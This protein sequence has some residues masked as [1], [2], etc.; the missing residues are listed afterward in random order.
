MLLNNKWL[1]R[2]S[3]IIVATLLP[4]FTHE[5]FA[6]QT[7]TLDGST[8]SDS[9]HFSN[10]YLINLPINVGSHDNRILIVTAGCYLGFGC[11]DVTKVQIN[12]MN[13]TKAI[14]ATDGTDDYSSIWYLTENAG[15]GTGLQNVVVTYSSPY[16][17]GTA[18]VY[19]LYNVNQT[20]PIGATN[21]TTNSV[22][23]PNA[24]GQITPT[25]TGSWIIDDLHCV[26]FSLPS[27]ALTLGWEE[28]NINSGNLIGQSQYSTTPIIGSKNNM[29][30]VNA[31]TA[32]WTWVGVEII[33]TASPAQLSIS[34]VSCNQAKATMWTVMGILPLGVFFAIFAVLG[35][36]KPEGGIINIIIPA[37]MAIAG[38]G[39]GFV[40]LGGVGNALVC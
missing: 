24:I 25:N 39:I 35:S 34:A 12:S 10:P 40:A 31:N 23:G 17:Y 11:T 19:S 22:F 30:W 26:C 2:I 15:L 13:F 38:I 14:D 21:S 33:P 1:F 7:I 36:V 20:N 29:E 28:Q 9:S 5:A 16:P 8:V 27:A 4:I 37:V 18:G 3:I 32:F 6:V